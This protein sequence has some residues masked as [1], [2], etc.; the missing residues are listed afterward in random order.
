MNTVADQGRKLSGRQLGRSGIDDHLRSD[1]VHQEHGQVHAKH[2]G[3][4]IECQ[5]LLNKGKVLAHLFCRL[6]ELLGLV[7]FTD[8][9]FYHTD[10]GYVLLHGV[11]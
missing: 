1:V 4:V 8:K 10:T 6:V 2:H 7:G 3:R 5:D 9:G 11:I